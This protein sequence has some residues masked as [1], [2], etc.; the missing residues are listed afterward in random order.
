MENFSYQRAFSRNI[1][2][3]TQGEQNYLRGKKIAI[4]GLGGVGGNHL[5][6]LSRMGFE[7]FHLADFDQFEIENFNRQCGA[8]IDHLGKSKLDVM[9]QMALQINPHIEIS[10]FP[11]GVLEHNIDE[12]LNECELY[13]DGLDFFAIEIRRLVFRKALEKNIPCI[14]VAPLGMGAA[15]LVFLPGQMDFDHYFGLKNQPKIDQL[16]KF[17]IGLA[18]AMTQSSYLVDKN[19][20]NFETQKVP[21]TPMACELCASIATTLAVKILLNRGH[22][23]AAPHGF[24][25]DMYHNKQIHTWRPLGGFSPL[26]WL[27]E[28]QLKKHMAKNHMRH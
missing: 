2:W 4:A 7:N 25:Y 8:Q 23:L 20:I 21:S 10:P 1:G 24:Q 17:L 3:V 11:K 18:P 22:V 16:I 15:S 9:T 6:T 19:C 12:F 14:T 26:Q 28:Y 13:I 27:K 5:L